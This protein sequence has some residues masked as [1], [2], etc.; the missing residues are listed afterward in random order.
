LLKYEPIL[1]VAK[2]LNYTAMGVGNHDFDDGDNGLIPFIEKCG[3]PVL[4]ANINTTDPE[5]EAVLEK[6]TVVLVNGTQVSIN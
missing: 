5:L 3:F 4:G 2:V 1:D 6:S